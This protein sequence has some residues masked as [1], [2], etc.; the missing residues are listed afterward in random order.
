MQ[1]FDLKGRILKYWGENRNILKEGSCQAWGCFQSAFGVPPYLSVVLGSLYPC[2]TLPEI[3][4]VSWC[5]A[6]FQMSLCELTS[7][8]K[9]SYTACLQDMR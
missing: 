7:S 4:R 2:V 6:H 1:E 9:G 5:F 3:E 8:W